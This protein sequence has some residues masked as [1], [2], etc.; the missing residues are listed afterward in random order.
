MKKTDENTDGMVESPG[1]SAI[2]FGGADDLSSRT[3]KWGAVLILLLSCLVSTLSLESV[4][5]ESH[6]ALVLQTAKEMHD[7]G[8]W[9][10]PF[11]NGVPRLNKPPLSYWLTAGV[12]SITGKTFEVKKWHGRIISSAAGVLMTWIALY[13]GRKLISSRAGLIAGV[14]CTTSVGFI[15]YSHNARPDFLFAGLLDVSLVGFVVA[16]KSADGSFKQMAG[17]ALMWFFFSLASLTK[18]P[19]VAIMLLVAWCIFLLSE[20]SERRRILPVIRPVTGVVILVGLSLPWWLLLKHQLEAQGVGALEGSQLS[21][22][23]FELSLKT[24][25]SGYYLW[26]VVWMMLPW[27]ALLPM[28][29]FAPWRD[30]KIGSNVRLLGTTVLFV[31]LAFSLFSHPRHHYLLQLMPALSILIGGGATVLWRRYEQM[32]ESPRIWTSV[33]WINGSIALLASIAFIVKRIYY[34]GSSLFL[35]TASAVTAAFLMI[36]AI[37]YRKELTRRASAPLIFSLLVFLPVI[38]GAITSHAFW[39]GSRTLVE[40]FCRSTGK[41]TN[42]HVPLIVSDFEERLFVYYGHPPVLREHNGDPSALKLLMGQMQ[43]DE[44][45]LVAPADVKGAFPEDCTAEV[46]QTVED[47]DDDRDAVLYRVRR[48]PGT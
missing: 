28:I 38:F 39:R 26:A 43:E 41:M 46:V 35:L 47:F 32:G 21:G 27:L 9:I 29:W 42:E 18:G 31:V 19:H 17:A 5:L 22:S 45:L 6:E 1:C 7:R 8:D 4:P 13:L 24:L 37:D 23:L 14:V 2:R 16:W 48:R 30:E 44:F 3:F 11:F 15:S 25:F 34:G 12:T 36:A 33:L 20:S 40:D 10:V